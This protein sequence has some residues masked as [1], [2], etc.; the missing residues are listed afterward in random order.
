MTLTE[1]DILRIKE[2]LV[3]TAH[4]T[5]DIKYN[6]VLNKI[7]EMKKEWE[8]NKKKTKIKF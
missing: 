5:G 6:Q 1:E 8:E 3:M 2:A 4:Y 7:L